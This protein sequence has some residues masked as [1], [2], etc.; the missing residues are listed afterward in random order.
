MQ[1]EN[2]QQR[3]NN[4]SIDQI[5][6]D[7]NLSRDKKTLINLNHFQDG[8]IGKYKKE[9]CKEIQKLIKKRIQFM[10]Y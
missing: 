4:L 9:L 5:E 2:F 6:I 3:L 1:V 10:P 7:N 8:S